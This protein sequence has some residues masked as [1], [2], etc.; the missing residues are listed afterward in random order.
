MKKSIAFLEEQAAAGD[1]N[2]LFTLGQFY[3]FLNLIFRHVYHFWVVLFALEFSF[4]HALD[5]L[6]PGISVW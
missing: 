5:V 3:E 6:L 2:A 1:T 4:D